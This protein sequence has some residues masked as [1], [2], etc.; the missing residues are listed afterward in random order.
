VGAAAAAAAV[1][2]VPSHLCGLEVD[3][4]AWAPVHDFSWKRGREGGR[5]GGRTQL[6]QAGRQSE[7]RKEENK[8]DYWV[9]VFHGSQQ[10]H[11][12]GLGRKRQKERG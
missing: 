8:G 9:C 12:S 3:D 2:V 11:K 5:E 10:I 7:E 4:L 6:K 1:V